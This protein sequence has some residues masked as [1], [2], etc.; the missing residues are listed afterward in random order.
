MNNDKNVI[1]IAKTAE[2]VFLVVLLGTAMILALTTVEASISTFFSTL[3]TTII[4]SG[5]NL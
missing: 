4:N 5:A 2:Y 1:D 3:S